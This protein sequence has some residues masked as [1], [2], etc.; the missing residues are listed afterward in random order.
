MACLQLFLPQGFCILIVSARHSFLELSVCFFS[1]YQ[2]W[3]VVLH[4]C[5]VV[6]C[7]LN[8]FRFFPVKYLVQSQNADHSS[9]QPRPMGCPYGFHVLWMG[10]RCSG[11][12]ASHACLSNCY[13][14]MQIPRSSHLGSQSI[15]HDGIF[16]GRLVVFTFLAYHVSFIF[17]YS[18]VQPTIAI[19]LTVSP[20]S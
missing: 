8:S 17:S 15:V 19:M 20:G 13:E 2:I 11:W 4:S 6:D 7:R 9:T 10:C 16:P 14:G 18:K 12:C 5:S 1:S 3:D